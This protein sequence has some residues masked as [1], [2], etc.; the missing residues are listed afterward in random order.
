MVKHLK[1][2]IRNVRDFPKKGIVFRDI[3]TLLKDSVHFSEI[4]DRMCKFIEKRMVDKIA[5][6]ES[7]G[8]ILGAAIAYKLGKGFVPLRKPGKLPWKTLKH[9]FETEYSKDAFEIHIDA[10]E[11]KDRVV[12]VD[13]VLATGGTALASAK[14]VEKLGGIVDSMLFL[15]ELKH[16]HG[17]KKL[18]GYKIFSLIHYDGNE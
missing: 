2:R 13:D 9:E 10:I 16:L 12:I 18:T 15:I 4:I 6:A 17:R 3:T 1:K 5:A 14:L 11:K 7:R 8:F